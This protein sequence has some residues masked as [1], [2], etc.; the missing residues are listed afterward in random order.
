[1]ILE[2]IKFFSENVSSSGKDDLLN[3]ELIAESIEKVASGLDNLA[4]A[5]KE[6][7]ASI[8]QVKEDESYLISS[9]H[10]KLAYKS[11]IAGVPENAIADLEKAMQFDKS[12]YLLWLGFVWWKVLLLDKQ[13]PMSIHRDDL[14]NLDYAINYSAKA[15]QLNYRSKLKLLF[16][17]IIVGKKFNST[18]AIDNGISQILKIIDLFEILNF[19][20]YNHALKSLDFLSE[21]FIEK[22]QISPLS[23]K[24]NEAFQTEID[25]VHN[26]VKYILSL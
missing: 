13:K 24:V 19:E 11:L 25:I 21:F 26:K 10:L 14:I 4:I 6:I 2:I 8:V 7:A 5:N 23:T 9:G 17:L 18:N 12:N 15:E 22:Y 20:K 3:S 16:N 1:M